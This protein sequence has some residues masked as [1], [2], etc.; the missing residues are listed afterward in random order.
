M[1]KKFVLG[2]YRAKQLGLEHLKK[3]TRDSQ[4]WQEM[5]RNDKPLKSAK[6]AKTD[7]KC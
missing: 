7:K 3:I 6:T 2:L 5:A 4:K 1:N